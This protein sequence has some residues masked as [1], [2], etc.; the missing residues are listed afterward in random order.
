[1]ISNIIEKLDNSNR[2]TVPT[3]KGPAK[4]KREEQELGTCEQG[5][6]WPGGGGL[7]RCSDTSSVWSP[8]SRNAYTVSHMIQCW[9]IRPLRADWIRPN[10]IRSRSGRFF[11]V[12]TFLY[13]PSKQVKLIRIGTGSGFNLVVK[14]SDLDPAKRFGS[15]ALEV[16]LHVRI[17]L[18]CQNTTSTNSS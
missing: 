3:S 18:S 9:R 8:Q 14:I 1:M 13:T 16:F 6:G 12:G 15:P 5:P 10:K 17:I 2:K 7:G 11:S 4:K